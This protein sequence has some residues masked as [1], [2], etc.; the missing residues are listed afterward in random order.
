MW[1]EHT[2]VVSGGDY[3]DGKLCFDYTMPKCAHHVTAPDLVACD[4]IK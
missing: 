3:G 2:G 1:F 4:S